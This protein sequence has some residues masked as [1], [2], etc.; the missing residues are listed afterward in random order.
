MV[1]IIIIYIPHLTLTSER[2]VETLARYLGFL[3]L[4][5]R[6]I[7]LLVSKPSCLIRTYKSE[8]LSWRQSWKSNR[9]HQYVV[10]YIFNIYIYKTTA[11]C[12]C[13]QKENTHMLKIPKSM[14]EVGRLWLQVNNW[15]CTKKQQPKNM[16][17]AASLFK[18]GELSIVDLFLPNSPQ[19][20]LPAGLKVKLATVKSHG[21]FSH[22]FIKFLYPPPKK[23]NNLNLQRNIKDSR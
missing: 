4:V 9:F 1:S 19:L 17:S 8:I 3:K 10:D 5:R 16:W 6:W 18:S 2:E 21:L 12:M 15:A 20:C 14:S 13:M 7:S 22:I 23:Q 11:A